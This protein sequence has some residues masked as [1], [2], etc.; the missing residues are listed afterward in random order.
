MDFCK[1]LE[2]AQDILPLAI[3]TVPMQPWETP[4]NAATALKQGTIFPCLDKPFYVTG[5]EKHA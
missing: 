1:N 4:Y 2:M 3:A 5:G